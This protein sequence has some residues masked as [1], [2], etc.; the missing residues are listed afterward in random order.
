MPRILSPAYFHHYNAQTLQATPDSRSTHAI[1]VK[2]EDVS[3]RSS[4]TKSKDTNGVQLVLGLGPIQ[5][6]VWR[7]SK[8][9]PLEG[10]RRH[11]SIFRR[12]KNVVREASHVA[13]HGIPLA[14]DEAGTQLQPLEI[15]EG[16][17][18]I[19]LIPLPDKENIE[20]LET[21]GTLADAKNSAGVGNSRRW[22]RVPSF[23]SYVPFGQV[24]SS[25][26]LLNLK[27]LERI[28]DVQRPFWFKFLSR[29]LAWK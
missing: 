14:V 24:A 12:V 4:I 7:L 16:S 25:S 21:N 13:D 29:K 3:K 19:S 9:V 28:L 11:L 10:V 2:G 17:E 8:L 6:S 1:S 18:G 22:S 20:S 15:E 5:T 27:L 23:P 26:F